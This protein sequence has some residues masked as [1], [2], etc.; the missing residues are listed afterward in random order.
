MRSVNN[1]LKWFDVPSVN[2]DMMG[3]QDPRAA[4]HHIFIDCMVAAATSYYVYR[5]KMKKD[6]STAKNVHFRKGDEQTLTRKECHR[7]S[8][9]TS[10]CRSNYFRDKVLLKELMIVNSGDP[11]A[12]IT[13][14]FNYRQFGNNAPG[15]NAPNR[16]T[17]SGVGAYVRSNKH[18]FTG[19]GKQSACLPARSETS[20]PAERACKS[21]AS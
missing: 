8:A 11:A 14:N 21:P 12:T 9:L 7:N 6:A 19:Y 17:A 10:V 13:E 4:N 5:E 20:R 3:D 18:N 2:N 16:L 1:L 15:N